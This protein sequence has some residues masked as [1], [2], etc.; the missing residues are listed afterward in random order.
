VMRVID[1]T[2]VVLRLNTDGTTAKG[3]PFD[4]DPDVDPPEDRIFAYGFRDPKSVLIDPA[5]SYLWTSERSDG[6]F[7]E[8]DVFLSGTNGGHAPYKGLQSTVPKNL[9]SDDLPNPAYPLVDLLTRVK[10]GVTLP[11][12]TYTN[13]PFSFESPDVHPTGLAFGGLEVGP[14]HRGD[15]FAGTEDGRLLRFNVNPFRT[16]FSLLVP[17]ADTIAS[18]GADEDDPETDEDETEPDSLT[19]LLIATGFGAISDLEAGVDGSMYV[20][21]QANGT[22]HRIF[23]DATR[24][25]AVQSVKAPKKISLSAKKPV[26]TK[27]IRVTLENRGEVAERIHSHDELESLIGLQLTSPTGCAIPTVT[28]VDPKYALPPYP[29]Q[30]GIAPNGGRATFQVNVA[31]ACDSPFDAGANNFEASVTVDMGT[32]GVVELPEHQADNVCPR[33]PAPLADP[34]DAGCGAKQPDGTLGGPIVT[35]ITIK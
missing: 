4:L 12:S 29:Y 5:S 26:V 21:D 2:S 27:A 33:P 13:P 35:D 7:D 20:V 17:L 18:L 16:G 24:D 19:Q 10:N 28:V 22:I 34:P 23:Y 9:D 14:Q 30:I 3:N 8:L 25:L 1:D 31:W 6:G 32:I 15:L 11:V